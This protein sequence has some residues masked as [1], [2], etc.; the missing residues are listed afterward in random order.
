[1]GLAKAKGKGLGCRSGS[2][3]K[4]LLHKKVPIVVTPFWRYLRKPLWVTCCVILSQFIIISGQKAYAH[5][6][7]SLIR[8]FYRIFARKLLRVVDLGRKSDLT[9]SGS[10][11]ARSGFEGSEGYLR[12][13]CRA[14]PSCFWQDNQVLLLL[15]EAVAEN[16]LALAG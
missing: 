3:V 7:L 6:R 1:M 8:P 16:R 11:P 5:V 2:D 10:G 9:G 15:M 12:L 14:L 13:C 4:M